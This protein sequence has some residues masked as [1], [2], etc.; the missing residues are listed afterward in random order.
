MLT[1]DEMMKLGRREDDPIRDSAL[2]TAHLSVEFNERVGRLLDALFPVGHDIRVEDPLIHGSARP[3]PQRPLP[4]DRAPPTPLPWMP[5]SRC[6]W[7]NVSW[8]SLDGPPRPM[9]L[10]VDTSG[11]AL[12]RHEELIG[13]NGYLAHVAACVDLARRSGFPSLSLV[14][15]EAVSGGFLRSE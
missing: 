2:Q 13:I 5:R 7:P 11:Q 12:S 8:R 4:Y 1:A 3:L 14:Y 6:R 10:L 15:G 9:V